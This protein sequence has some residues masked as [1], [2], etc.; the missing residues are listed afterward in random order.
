MQIAKG[1]GDNGIWR[2]A[3][4]NGILYL[5]DV[6]FED[7]IILLCLRWYF[8][9][10]LSYRDLVVILGERGLSISHTTILRWVVRYADTCEKR[11]RRFERPV[12]GSWRV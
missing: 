11:W 5:P 3:K 4:L 6:W 10:K 8:R 7:D 1:L 2:I 9:F 12:G